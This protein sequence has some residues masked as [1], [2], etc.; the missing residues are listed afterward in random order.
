MQ[1]KSLAGV[2]FSQLTACFNEAF[3][4]YF[5][6]FQV[7]E[8][9]LSERWAAASVDYEL[10]RGAYIGERLVGFIMIALADWEGETSHYNAG[11]GVIPD[12]RGQGL[13]G[14]MYAPLL[15][16]LQ[17]RSV[18][19]GLLEVIAQNER[20]IKA[21]Q[22]VGYQIERRL[23]CFKGSFPVFTAA[24]NAA[25]Q[26]SAR[27]D[28]DAYQKLSPFV[29]TWDSQTPTA[30][31]FGNAVECW[32]YRPEDELLAFAIYHRVSK[33]LVQW[34]EAF[35]EGAP[36]NNLLQQVL[37]GESEVRINNIDASATAELQ[38]MADLGMSPSLDQFEMW[39]KKP[40]AG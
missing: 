19:Q 35:S 10:S 39:R 1:I 9:Y 25:I 17:D 38:R 23:C 30:K 37:S 32:E 40:S 20:A 7:D 24:Q 28:W 8:A 3:S 29:W 21:Y 4:D 16:E 12:F 22:K 36:L 11:T 34:G 31:K 5:L 2:D 27:P 26:R 13:M 18:R 6:P 15:A 14:Q 33:R